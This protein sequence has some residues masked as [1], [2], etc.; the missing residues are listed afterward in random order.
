MIKRELAK[1][2][3]LVNESWDRFLPKFRR[4]HLKTSE[5]TERKNERLKDK[6]EA[7]KAAG[8]VWPQ[9]RRAISMR[10]HSIMML[11]S[12]RPEDHMCPSKE[13]VRQ[14]NSCMDDRVAH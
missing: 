7:R 10:W 4:H 1:D 9:D 2:P 8:L 5:K 3:Q 12:I 6:N 14:E 11:K 13:R